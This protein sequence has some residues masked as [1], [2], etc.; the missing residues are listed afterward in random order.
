VGDQVNPHFYVVG[1]S[2][3]LG[4]ALKKIKPEWTYLTRD[5]VNLSDPN[6]IASYFSQKAPVLI[7]FAS[8]T[9][10]DDAEKKRAEAELINIQA[11]GA[12][13]KCCDTFIQISTDYVFAG[14]KK[15]PYLESD[16]TSPVNFYGHTKLAGE[17]AALAAN[18][19][20][21]IV[22]TSWLYS[23]F[24]KNFVKRMIELSQTRDQLKIVN[25]QTGTPTFAGDLVAAVATLAMNPDPVAGEIFHYSNLGQCTWYEFTK[26]I[27]RLKNIPTVVSPIS[28]SE[29][30][31]PAARPV[32]SVLDK[33]KIV[34]SANIKIP[35]W[36]ESLALFLE[37]YEKAPTQ[38][39]KSTSP[40]FFV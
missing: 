38:P 37:T 8:F 9:A 31:L 3:Q 29:Y 11:V 22:R 21:I 19:R 7:N 4:Q 34:K 10:V 33:N 20:S 14:D 24:G 28:T 12:L 6:S 40:T 17:H 15:T 16:K 26:E 27:F 30:P 1:A 2:S 39:R 5:D 35:T 13:A 18:P 36:Q 25:D 23:E 32:F